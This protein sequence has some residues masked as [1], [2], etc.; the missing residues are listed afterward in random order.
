[1]FDFAI[2]RCL[3]T[4]Y[5]YADAIADQIDQQDSHQ[6][7]SLVRDNLKRIID[8][9]CGT[10]EIKR[11]YEGK[12]ESDPVTS[13]DIFEAMASDG[14]K[15]ALARR[16]TSDMLVSFNSLVLLEEYPH[17]GLPQKVGH[18]IKCIT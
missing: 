8:G 3:R 15:V 16:I 11:F 14:A 7:I 5:D 6:K 13:R 2:S 18:G 12:L 1:M 17:L 10:L 9:L 4:T